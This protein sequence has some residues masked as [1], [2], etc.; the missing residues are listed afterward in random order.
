MKKLLLALVLLPGLAV[1]ADYR[2]VVGVDYSQDAGNTF[3][4]A[5]TGTVTTQAGV[6]ISSPTLSLYN[7]V[8]SGKNLTV[9]EVTPVFTASPAAAAAFALAFNITPSSGVF[10]SSGG[11][12]GNIVSANLVAKST[13]TLTTAIAK[14]TL[15][16]VLPATPTL[17]RFLSQVTG[18]AAIGGFN[19]TDQTQGKIVVP[20]GGLISLQTTSSVNA[21]ASIEWRED[22][23]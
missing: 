9:L 10:I 1:A 14:C 22:S 3:Y 17:F 23:Q 21:Q 12:A 11:V 6:S 15:Q 2:G 4:C 16:G 5:S 7:P 13:G 20:P 8:G 18:A 19:S